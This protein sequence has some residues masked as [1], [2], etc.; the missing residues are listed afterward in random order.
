MSLLSSASQNHCFFASRVYPI[1]VNITQKQY[2]YIHTLYIQPIYI[3]N[4]TPRATP[5][6]IIDRN[7]CHWTLN[8]NWTSSSV[9]PRSTQPAVVATGGVPKCE[10]KFRGYIADRP[11]VIALTPSPKRITLN[12]THTKTLH[13]TTHTTTHSDLLH[14]ESDR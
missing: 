9:S 10:E 12:N 6:V 8:C 13:T 11:Q 2:I 7:T 14:A 4:A 1:P 3:P 5:N